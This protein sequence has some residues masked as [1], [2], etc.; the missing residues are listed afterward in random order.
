MAEST[1]TKAGAKPAASTD[2]KL[3]HPQGGATTRDDALDSGAPMLAGDPSEPVGPEDALG[4]GQK[5]GDYRY[6][7]TRVHQAAVLNPNH[8]PEDPTSPRVVLVDQNPLA[9]QIGD[10]AGVKGGTHPLSDEVK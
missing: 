3:E 4:S 6:W 9:E 10:E 2:S 1:N 7:Q 8:D 5:R